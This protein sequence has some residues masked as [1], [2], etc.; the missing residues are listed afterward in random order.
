[1][2]LSTDATVSDVDSPDFGGGQL[3]IRITTGA[4]S[5]N[6]IGISGGTFAVDGANNVLRSGI[7]IGKI[8]AGGGKGKTDLIVTFT[9]SAKTAIVEELVQGAFFKTVGGSAGTR[10]IAFSVSDGDGG[11]SA[12]LTKT[13]VV[14]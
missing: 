10:K 14:T 8:N 1:V 13:I 4:S 7:V 12:E 11:T 9:T 5:S 3:R 6:V 2:S